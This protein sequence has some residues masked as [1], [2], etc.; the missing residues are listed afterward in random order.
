MIAVLLFGVT[1]V[2]CTLCLCLWLRH[3]LN[4]KQAEIEE[5]AEQALR[6]WV[7]PQEGNKPSKLAEM[8]SA[9]GSV[10]GS[11]AAQSIMA[12][13]SASNSQAARQANGLA[14]EALAR[15]NPALG[16]LTG[17]K[18]G[19]G[20]AIMRLGE[21]LGDMFN[22]AGGAPSGNGGNPSSDDVADRIGRLG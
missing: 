12:S 15:K 2:L 13:M 5:K 20:A 7:Q 21:L 19:K 6:D 4:A 18:R 10:I 16:L 22:G 9:T 1:E 17:G 3:I 11:A 8:L 14:D